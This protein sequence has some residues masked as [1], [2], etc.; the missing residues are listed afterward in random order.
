M[1]IRSQASSSR[2]T[3][4]NVVPLLDVVFAILAVFVLLSAGLSLPQSIGVD[5]PSSGDR[6]GTNN[7]SVPPEMLIFT[8]DRSGDLYLRELPVTPLMIEDEIKAFLQA[9][10]QGLVVLNAQD[11]AV[12]YQNVIIK[13]EQMRKIAGD[14]VAIATSSVSTGKTAK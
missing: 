6:S 14:R 10:P 8:L 9:K 3:E 2:P 1:K 4:I 11:E 7:N 5:L 12:S 13:L